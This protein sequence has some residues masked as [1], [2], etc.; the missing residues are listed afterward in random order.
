M[1]ALLES[2]PAAPRTSRRRHV[3]TSPM[4]N[5]T[6][7]QP[8]TLKSDVTIQPKRLRRLFVVWVLA[9]SVGMALVVYGFGPLFHQRDQRSLL[10]RYRADIDRAANQS[11]GLA[12]VTVP[13]KAP[14]AGSSVGILEIGAVR[15]QQIVL[16]GIGAAQTASGPG[17]VPGTAGLGQ[18]GNSVLVGRN[19]A[20][21]GEFGKLHSLHNGDQILVTTTQGQSVYEVDETRRTSVKTPAKDNGGSPTSSSPDAPTIDDVYGPSEDD[22]LTLV[23]SASLA[24]WNTSEAT[25]VIAKLK[26]EPFAPTP[27]GGLID[28]AT[29]TRGDDG[30]LAAV[31]LALLT[32]GLIMGGSVTLYRMLRARTAYLLTIAPIVALTVISAETFSRL[33]PAWM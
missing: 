16:E 1:T 25:V 7:S 32:Y 10:N 8:R 30:A 2:P 33:L 18:P 17:H 15:L 12:G 26:T 9:V 24:P 22:R 23:T 19:R 27:Q 28:R 6:G 3:A 20:F 13:T 5:P 11:T 31:V 4:T 29:G 14:G 21:G